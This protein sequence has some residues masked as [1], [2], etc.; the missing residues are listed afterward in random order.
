M[1]KVGKNQQIQSSQPNRVKS[2]LI[3]GAY[4]LFEESGLKL[5]TCNIPIGMPNICIDSPLNELRAYYISYHNQIAD[6]N[7]KYHH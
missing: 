6:L 5:C 1:V 4:S 3:C 7:P 2:N